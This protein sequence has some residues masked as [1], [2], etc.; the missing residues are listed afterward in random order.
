MAMARHHKGVWSKG[1]TKKNVS[2]TYGELTKELTKAGGTAYRKRTKVF[3][4][5]NGL[6]LLRDDGH[7]N[8]RGM[9]MGKS[10]KANGKW[11][12]AMLLDCISEQFPEVVRAVSRSVPGENHG[13]VLKHLVKHT[14]Y[15][16][17]TIKN[18]LEYLKISGG[19]Q[20]SLRY[21]LNREMAEE[22]LVGCVSRMSQ[23]RDV[24]KKNLVDWVSDLFGLDED[25]VMDMVRGLVT[26]RRL[27]YSGGDYHLLV[28][29][30]G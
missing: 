16:Q 20:P 24:S 21:D 28:V 15:S 4:T 3:N 6:G 13:T 25:T 27:A 18:I 23:E 11:F 29:R 12:A 1:Q 30:E 2:L 26:R 10:S 22:F 8:D 9:Q 5:L 7:L 14:P 19:L 17:D